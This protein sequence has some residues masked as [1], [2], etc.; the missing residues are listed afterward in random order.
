MRTPK[1]THLVTGCDAIVWSCSRTVFQSL[2]SLL[3]SCPSLQGGSMPA[4]HP[5]VAGR[6]RAR[7]APRGVHSRGSES[8]GRCCARHAARRCKDG[9][10]NRRA[11]DEPASCWLA[12]LLLLR[13]WQVGRPTGLGGAWTTK[14]SIHPCI[15]WMRGI[16]ADPIRSKHGGCPARGRTP[17][18]G[19]A[20]LAAADAPTQ[21]RHRRAETTT[22]VPDRI[23]LTAAGVVAHLERTYAY[24][25]YN[26]GP[27]VAQAYCLSRRKADTAR[28]P[29]ASNPRYC[30]RFV[31][32]GRWRPLPVSLGNGY[33]WPVG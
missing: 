33:E 30:C 12:P 25:A 16:S 22:L 32:V 19:A 7:T 20:R 3:P 2:E 21:V 6:V 24:S 10:R 11:A 26:C 13:R 27:T 4:G 17:W 9:P 15:A 5:R 28:G 1:A 29:P 18:I 14:E 31:G 23:R 8:H